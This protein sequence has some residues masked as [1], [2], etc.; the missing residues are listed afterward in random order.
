M[1]NRQGLYIHV[2]FCSHRCSYCE[3]FSRAGADSLDGFVKRLLVEAKQMAQW[4]RELGNSERM[5]TIFFGGG[6]PSLLSADGRAQVLSALH[7]LFDVSREA[8]ITL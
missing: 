5:D 6:T 1:T 7:G 3:F 4:W 2:P 8:E